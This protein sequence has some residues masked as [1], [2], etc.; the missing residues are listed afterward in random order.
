M[1]V[2]AARGCC[3]GGA[4][5]QYVGLGWAKAH[6][7]HESGTDPGVLATGVAVTDG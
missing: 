5:L 7:A 2:L 6:L 1:L 3:G 4:H